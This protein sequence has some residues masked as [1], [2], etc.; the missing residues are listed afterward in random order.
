MITQLGHGKLCI[1]GSITGG[2]TTLYGIK[3]A[4]TKN[5]YV[6]EWNWVEGNPPGGRLT[7]RMLP[8]GA[9]FGTTA[10]AA[11]I[12]DRL[13]VGGANLRTLTFPNTSSTLAQYWSAS[14]LS[15]GTN[16]AWLLNCVGSYVFLHRYSKA[17]AYGVRCV[18][19]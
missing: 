12:R 4:G 10:T 9:A 5:A 8:V 7:I 11:E 2:A 1:N 15:S 13:N 19:N 3:K 18:P 17:N 16:Y 14:E 6:L